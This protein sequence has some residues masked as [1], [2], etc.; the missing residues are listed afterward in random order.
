MLAE[1]KRLSLLIRKNS[2]R[3]RLQEYKQFFIGFNLKQLEYID[4]EHSDLILEQ[5]KNIFPLTEKVSEIVEND[6]LQDSSFLKEILDSVS[7][8]D[9]CYIYNDAV[10]ECGMFIANTKSIFKNCLE[11]AFL[12]Y[13]SNN[14]VFIVD[15]DLKFSITI[16]YYDIEDKYYPDKFEILKKVRKETN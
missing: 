13:N 15:Y 7:V 5:T 4:L 11:M 3:P 1:N 8:N 9:K 10:Y 6:Q 12:T 16:D 14:T 2:G